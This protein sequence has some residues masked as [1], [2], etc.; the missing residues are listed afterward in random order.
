MS[1]RDRSN[2][3]PADEM[4]GAIDHDLRSPVANIL[5]FVDLLR[6]APAAPLSREQL[7]FLGRIEQNC[8][9]LLAVVERLHLAMRTRAS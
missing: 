9:A 7:E 4:L 8:H 2:S 1:T 5:G 6:D 3:G